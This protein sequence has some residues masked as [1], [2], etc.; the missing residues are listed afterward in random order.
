M[1]K[2]KF[3][4]VIPYVGVPIIVLAIIILGVFKMETFTILLF[5]L[6]AIFGYVAT[7]FDIKTKKIPNSLII[8]MLAGWIIITIPQLFINIEETLIFL[9][10]SLFGSLIGGGLSL[11]VYLISRKGLGGGDVKFITVAGLYLGISGV[12]PAML[13]GSILAGLTGLVLILIKKIGRKDAIPL[14]P[15]LYVGILA[16]VFFM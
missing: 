3:N 11:L 15:F 5:C 16:V 12:L 2:I 8:A 1:T 7:V 6:L 14:A 4:V 9:R 10:N 13:V